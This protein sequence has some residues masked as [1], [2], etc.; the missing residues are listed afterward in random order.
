MILV[1]VVAFHKKKIEGYKFQDDKAK[2]DSKN[3]ISQKDDK[4]MK[5]MF[6]NGVCYIFNQHF[7]IR[8]DGVHITPTL[9]RQ[10]NEL[11]YSLSNCK[12]YCKR[13][14]CLKSDIDDLKMIKLK[15][16]LNNFAYEYSLSITLGK[17]D[18]DN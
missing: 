14:N 18:S 6:E 10:D 5:A 4:I 8:S 11:G 1:H 17:G 15:I 9:D 2:R 16:Q 13:C 7:G 12:P 3:N